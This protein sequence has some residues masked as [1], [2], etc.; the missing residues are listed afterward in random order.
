[1]LRVFKY[2][3]PIGDTVSIDVP[4][5][6]EPIGLHLQH[7]VPCMWMLVDP[8]APTRRRSFLVVPTGGEILVPRTDL[9]P[10]GTV[11]LY[12]GDFV[13][14]VFELSGVLE[15]SELA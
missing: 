8:D 10:V 9:K 14:H 7:G 12:G 2:E 3:L 13:M 5:G 15:H 1:M 4:A 11:L 6:S